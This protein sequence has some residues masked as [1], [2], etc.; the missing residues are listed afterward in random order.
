MSDSVTRSAVREALRSMGANRSG[1][2]WLALASWLVLG[3]ST[4]ARLGASSAAHAADASTRGA[5]K[6]LDAAYGLDASARGGM[7]LDAGAVASAPDGGQHML[8]ADAG[9]RDAAMDAATDGGGLQYPAPTTQHLSIGAHDPTM[10]HVGSTYYLLTTGG[11][12]EIR[13]STDLQHWT[14]SASVFAGL[15]AWIGSELGQPISDLWAPDISF[16]AGLYHVYY[17]GSVFGSNHSVIGLA[18]NTTLDPSAAGYG[19][20]DQGLVIESNKTGGAKDDWNAIDPSVAFDSGGQPWLVFGS[21]WSGI[22][23]RKLEPST[24][25]LWATDTQLYALASYPGGIEAPSIVTHAGYY[26]LFVSYDACCKGVNSTYR[27]MVGRSQSITGP[28]VDRAGQAML[29]G[30]AEELLKSDGRYIGPGGGTAFQDENLYYYV[31]HYYDGQQNG[32][33]TLMLRPIRWTPDSWPTLD[34]PLWQ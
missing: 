27:T 34:T 14:H 21:F 15:P 8:A 29:Q 12:L 16:F 5:M 30:N 17:A 26:Y 25:K 11:Q 24:G 1:K 9:T 2:A 6:T 23:L 31:H 18:T 10:I 32:A 13:S 19:W 20:V 7:T 3:C 33:P 4:S 28:Y 22:K